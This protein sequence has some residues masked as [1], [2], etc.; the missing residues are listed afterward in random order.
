LRDLASWLLYQE[1]AYPR[2]IDLGL[3][4]LQAVLDRLHWR[5]PEVPVI[6]V[7][8]TNGKGSVGAYTASIL[9]A[10]GFSSGLFTS[11]HLRDYRERIRIGNSQVSAEAL[12]AAFERIEAA[13]GDIGLT[14]FEY[15]T[16]A[17]ILVFEAARLD[18]WVMEIGLGGRLD[19]V[20]IIDPDVAV[21]VSIGLDH[22]DF[23][24]DTLDAI[25]AEKA[26]IFRRGRPAVLGSTDMPE[27]VLRTAAD[28]GARLKRLGSDFSHER[29]PGA[30]C[31]RY[32][33]VRWDLPDL[34]LP[35]LFGSTQLDNASTA[36]AALEELDSRLTIT[37]QAI[38]T[39]LRRAQLPARFQIITPANSGDPLWILD[40]AHNQS[41][42]R[43]LA[44][45][46]RALPAR[47]KTLAVFGVLADKDAR[48]IVAELA[49]VV[50]HWWFAATHG[51]RGLSDAAVAERV[52][53]LVG[54]RYSLGG[55]FAQCCE[56]AREAAMP[57]D[58]IVAFGSFHS[59][60]PVLDWLEAQGIVSDT[61][62]PEYN[63][64]PQ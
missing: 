14:F 29:E 7:A 53:D 54:G 56:R 49:P 52:G 6:T 1:Q 44:G 55:S 23:L 27:S 38:A 35:A 61:R 59:V 4:R 12:V 21:V 33:G 57:S 3:T 47:G 15:N 60:G 42:A 2:V 41:A 24:G 19:A 63:A 25:G 13:R 17:A 37:P 51:P 46:L 39:G 32:R 11:P 10:A 22:Q 36:I 8:G 62:I 34:P 18:A 45:N 48:A 26:G 43:V 40:V 31:W 64:D 20:N 30:S 5:R 28:V 50:D 9:Q 16:L 58:R